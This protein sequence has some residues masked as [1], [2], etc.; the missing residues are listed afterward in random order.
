MQQQSSKTIRKVKA[1][2]VGGGTAG[3]IV[4]I[5]VWLAGMYG[6]EVPAQVQGAFEIVIVFV[7]PAV[8][9]WLAGYFTS[10]AKE[11]GIVEK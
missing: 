7:A 6:L 3:A 2:A 4:V 11:D 8:G 10:P 9:A 5:I 1:A